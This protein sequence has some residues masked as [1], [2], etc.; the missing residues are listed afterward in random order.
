[1]RKADRYLPEK[2]KR[3]ESASLPSVTVERV[4]ENEQPQICSTVTT[5]RV[6][7]DDAQDQMQVLHYHFHAWPDHGVPDR[8]DEL[9][10]LVYAIGEKRRELDDCEVWVHW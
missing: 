3:Y 9:R 4:S 1:M 6:Q 5:L 8:V 7:A 2:R 10:Q